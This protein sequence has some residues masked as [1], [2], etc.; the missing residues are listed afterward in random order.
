MKRV[1]VLLGAL[2]LLLALLTGCAAP[3]P[4]PVPTPAPPPTPEPTPE[5]AAPPTLDAEKALPDMSGYV[6]PAAGENCLYVSAGA[7]GG[8]GT[9]E[10][11]FGTLTEA[12]DAARSADKTQPLYVVAAPGL[13][14]L[15]E[16]LVLTPEDSGVTWCAAADGVVLSGG[17]TLSGNWTQ[18]DAEKNI[19]VID[20]EG[21]DSRDLYINGQHRTLARSRKMTSLMFEGKTAFTTTSAWLGDIV[22]PSDVLVCI[23]G[24]WTTSYARV[25]RIER[26][27]EGFRVVPREDA[28]SIYTLS[29]ALADLGYLE[30]DY[31]F[32]DTPGEWYL[33]VRASR[34][35]YIPLEGEDMTAATAVLGVL[36]RLVTLEGL[37]D[38]NVTGVTFT[39]FTFSYTTYMQPMKEG[40]IIQMQANV[41]LPAGTTV[42]SKWTADQWV[43]STYAFETRYTTDCT[44]S[45]CTFTQLGMGGLLMGR[46]SK[47]ALVSRNVVADIAGT[48]IQ[49][50]LCT[51]LDN[52]SKSHSSSRVRHYT[53]NCTVSDNFITRV[54]TLYGGSVGIMVGYANAC[55]VEYNTLVDLPYTG[56][57]VGWGWGSGANPEN[58]MDD[59]VI[60][61]NYINNI[62]NVKID[63]GGIYTLG[64][65]DGTRIY[66]NYVGKCNNEFGAIYL[67]NGSR[68]ITVTNNAIY[69]A[70][71]NFIYKG[72]YNTIRDN[73][74]S[75]GVS[76]QPDYNLIEYADPSDTTHY[77]FENND[78]W[79]EARVL[80]IRDAAGVR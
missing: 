44:V 35:Y 11:P 40:G 24:S 39:G 59:N 29:P 10:R 18:Y 25:D 45:R 47:S 48:G 80:A 21:I 33:D 30:N 14:E 73:Y 43:A 54:G 36:E 76:G 72:D 23:E 75:P 9:A 58:D 20:A 52:G 19:W 41:Y 68:G 46:G 16:T 53:Q 4:T 66:D 51:S 3:V 5:P 74:A 12:R 62:M 7:A 77:V 57:S 70:H 71:R 8:D 13:Y 65:M 2:G 61:G 79:D 6:C 26:D 15:D 56:I 28:W 38:D 27:G 17:R 34:I 49:L 1:F 37:K 78:L 63:G 64:R 31:S 67:D 55:T 42:H 32:L 22:E 50:S 69:L 60:R